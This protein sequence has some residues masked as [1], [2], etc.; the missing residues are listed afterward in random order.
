MAKKNRNKMSVNVRQKRGRP[1]NNQKGYVGFAHTRNDLQHVCGLSDP[2][3]DHARGVKIPDEDSSKS[4]TVQIRDNAA[5]GSDANGRGAIRIAPSLQYTYKYG[6]VITAGEVTT[7]DAADYGVTDYPALDAGVK[8]FRI[9]SWGVRIYSQ[10]PPTNQSGSFRMIT[11]PNSSSSAG[12]FTYDSSFFEEIKVFPT[13]EDTVHWVS[14][15]IGVT[16]KEYDS[17]STTGLPWDYLTIVADGLPANNP[18]CLTVELVFN[19]EC[20]PHISSITGALSNDAA[21]H[22]PHVLAAAGEVLKKHGGAT[23]GRLASNI[24]ERTARVA[25]NFVS[26]RILGFSAISNRP[27][28]MIVD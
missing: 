3:C 23:L 19:L 5:I 18:A 8:S 2:F 26:R 6:N 10:L 11:T 14:K 12:A 24:L 15:P 17:V 25:L 16:W 9:V 7:W 22:K 1:T 4:F 21:E 13:S 20:Q 28:P 27:V